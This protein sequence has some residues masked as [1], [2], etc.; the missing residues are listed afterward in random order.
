LRPTI[1]SLDACGSPQAHDRRRSTSDRQAQRWRVA[2]SLG[3]KSDG[4]GDATTG[5][6]R[7]VGSE[8]RCVR[9]ERLPSCLRVADDKLATAGSLP[10]IDDGLPSSIGRG[11]GSEHLRLRP[12]GSLE[13]SASSLRVRIGSPLSVRG[14]PTSSE[15]V[16]ASAD[17]AASALRPSRSDVA[18]SS[19]GVTSQER[20]AVRSLM[21]VRI[22]KDRPRQGT[23]AGVVRLAAAVILCSGA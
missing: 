13:R 6:L 5:F 16:I 9:F 11:L 4:D 17:G 12:W 8:A 18:P 15:V 10:M 14:V 20:T 21:P 23:D 22:R 3:V 7:K 1:R 19:E 2:A